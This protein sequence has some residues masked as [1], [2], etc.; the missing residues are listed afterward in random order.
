MV[1]QAQPDQR[2]QPE[3]LDP[4]VQQELAAAIRD[5]RDP[6]AR[7]ELPELPEQMEHLDRREKPERQAQP[8]RQA[9]LVPLALRDLKATRGRQG[10]KATPVK[11]EARDHKAIPDQL[12]QLAQLARWVPLD[13]LD[14]RE[15]PARPEAQVQKGTQAISDLRALKDRKVRL[16]LLVAGEARISPLPSSYQP[17]QSW[18]QLRKPWL[19]PRPHARTA[20]SCWVAVAGSPATIPTPP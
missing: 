18:E 9:L 1:R 7:P 20:S 6:L 2:A 12:A 17:R 10:R 5:L 13:R 19:M 3:S 8:D 14:R 16:V 11:P 15:F 4:L